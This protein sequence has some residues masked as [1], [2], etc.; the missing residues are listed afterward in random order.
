MPDAV[1]KV[2]QRAPA[3]AMTQAEPDLAHAVVDVEP[4]LTALLTGY[5]IR[6]TRPEART[7]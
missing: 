6:T 7:L 2:L 4:R 1:S 3:R 5:A